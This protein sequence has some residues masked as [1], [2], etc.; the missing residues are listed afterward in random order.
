MRKRSKLSYKSELSTELE[1]Y[2]DSYNADSDVTMS[3][4]FRDELPKFLPH[5]VQIHGFGGCETGGLRAESG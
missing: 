3:C 5:I 4:I 1:A 2:F